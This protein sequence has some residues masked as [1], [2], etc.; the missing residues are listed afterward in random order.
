VYTLT[1]VPAAADWIS[2]IVAEVAVKVPVLPPSPP[3]VGG[4]QVG[5]NV[6]IVP[7]M[8]AVPCERPVRVPE[9]VTWSRVN[10]V[11][12]AFDNT[13]VCRRAPCGRPPSTEVMPASGSAY[14]VS[15]V[16]RK[17]P[18]LIGPPI[19]VGTVPVDS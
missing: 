4:G 8:A 2:V 1:T 3:S 7:A 18:L 13:N 12:V 5:V 16:R 15:D 19:P 17:V 6:T 11:E 10:D 14:S 9:I